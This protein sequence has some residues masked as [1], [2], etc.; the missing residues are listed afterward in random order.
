MV[1]VLVP[2]KLGS[3]QPLPLTGLECRQSRALDSTPYRSSVIKTP[4]WRGN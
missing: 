1:Q 3:S 4:S 2:V